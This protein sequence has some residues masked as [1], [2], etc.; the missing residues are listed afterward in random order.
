MLFLMTHTNFDSVGTLANDEEYQTAGDAGA[1]RLVM[2]LGSARLEYSSFKNSRSRTAPAMQ[3]I[4]LGDNTNMTVVQCVFANNRAFLAGGALAFKGANLAI[5]DSIFQGNA[6]EPPAGGV[7]LTPVYVRVHTGSMGVPPS[8]A[9]ASLNYPVWKVDGEEPYTVCNGVCSDPDAIWQKALGDNGE[10]ECTTGGWLQGLEPTGCV[11]GDVPSDEV[12]YGSNRTADTPHYNQ[13]SDY[14]EVLR[15]EPGPHKLWYGQNVHMSDQALGWV[16]GAWIDIVGIIDPMTDPPVT[17]FRAAP[18]TANSADF[19]AEG[20]TDYVATPGCWMGKA[21][22]DVLNPCPYGMT[23]WR[24]VDFEVPYGAGGAL[25][26]SSPG[27]TISIVNSQFVDNNAGTGSTLNIVGAQKLSVKSS[28]LAAGSVVSTADV[29]ACR[30]GACDIGQQCT[31]KDGLVGIF[32]DEPCP[33]TAFGNGY[34]CE[35]CDAGTE[36]SPLNTGCVPCPANQVSGVDSNCQA[37][38]VGKTHDESHTICQACE[39]GKYRAEGDEQCS[40][41]A[42]GHEPTAGAGSCA[43]CAEGGEVSPDGTNCVPCAT[44]SGVPNVERTACEPCSAGKAPTDDGF[45]CEVCFGTGEYSNSATGRCDICG[46]GLQ[47]NADRTAC[48]DCPVGTAGAGGTCTDCEPGTEPN[49]ARTVCVAC[50]VGMVSV[51]GT[52]CSSCGPGTA[53]NSDRRACERC[54]G[55]AYSTTGS[56][57]VDCPARQT[58]N[59]QKTECY[60]M[61]NTYNTQLTGVVTCN[62]LRTV[63]ELSLN[64]ECAA[65]PPC[66]DCTVSGTTALKQGWSFYGLNYAYRC[67]GK[68]AVAEAHCPGGPLRNLTDATVAW[69]PGPEGAFVDAVLDGQCASG[70]IGPIC[71]NCD[72]EHHHLKTGKQCETCDEG[73]VDIPMLIGLLFGLM[74]GGA[75]IIS[76]VY[77]VLVDHGIITDIRLLVGFFQMLGQMNNVLSI[78]FPQP[79]PFFLDVVSFLFLDARKLV[80]L[81]CW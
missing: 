53:P 19:S 59:D 64:D 16:G 37:C 10:I 77:N 50:P 71:S 49:A 67:K 2:A 17:D 30:P 73:R 39:E 55:D 4:G 79:V 56:T 78:S 40:P 15:L 3:F 20:Y 41:C 58:A 34:S 68:T 76:G 14:A 72:A 18:D 32:C 35:S 69:Q 9:S 60:C 48:V 5:I 45:A 44:G 29:D 43:R 31:Q 42:P 22:S 8:G 26:S 46:P 21:H 36:P 47:P 1:V 75:I 24:S 13:G 70:S 80:R 61:T 28:E 38:G 62:G 25:F 23:F 51:D 54:I 74:F 52:A 66:L 27:A 12:V 7:T 33:S 65:C 81:D 11:D 57:C 6:I 63:G